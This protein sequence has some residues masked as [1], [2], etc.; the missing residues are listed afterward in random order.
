MGP[1]P[2]CLPEPSSATFPSLGYHPFSL[3]TDAGSIPTCHFLWL[4]K[5][6]KSI[7]PN[8]PSEY[9]TISFLPVQ[10]NPPSTDLLSSVSFLRSSIW[11]LILAPHK[12]AFIKVTNDLHIAKSR[13]VVYR[14]DLGTSPSAA[15]DP[16]SHFPSRKHSPGFPSSFQFPLQVLS[17]LPIHEMLA[18]YW[19]LN[20]LLS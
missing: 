15:A 10:A 3:T 11:A 19:S 4:I 14:F 9:H 8:F 17:H 5:N 2:S 7:Y 16:V 20:T 13:E 12:T 1:I 6:K 18:L